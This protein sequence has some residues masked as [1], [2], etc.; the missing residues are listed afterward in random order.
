MLKSLKMKFTVGFIALALL[1]MLVSGVYLIKVL[2]DYFIGNL[3]DKLLVEAKL[4]REMVIDEFGSLNRSSDIEKITGNLGNVTSTRV[5]V[6]DANGVVLGDS[7]QLPT[8]MENHLRRPEIQQAISEGL[9]IAK[10]EST[11]LNTQMMYLA[12]PVEKDGEI[13]G[14]VRLALPMTE[15]T[16]ALSKLWSML[17]IA[18]LM[19]TVIAGVLGF[20]L[21]QRLTKPIQEMTAAAQNIAGGDFSLR[22]YTT[23]QDEIG[24]LGQALNQ[25]AQQLKEMI[26]EVSTGKSKLETVLANMVSGVIFLRE[27]GKIDLIN[28]AALK[29]LEIEPKNVNRHQ[30]EIINNYQLSTL[31]DTAL[32]THKAAKDD[33][34]ILSPHEKNIEVNITPILGKGNTNIGAVMVLH[35]ITDLRKLETM[36][37]DFVANVSHELKTPVTSLKGYAETLLDGALDDPETARE[38]VRIILTESERLR[39]LVDDLL[40]LSRI[41]SGKDSVEWQKI[42]VSA[43][44]HSL[45]VKFRPQLEAR[46]IELTVVCSEKL[47]Y[48]WGDYSM[49]EQVLTNLT[50]NAIKYSAIREKV[51]IVASEKS[52]GILFEVIDSGPGIPEH[53]LPRVFERFYRVDKGRNRKQGGTG[54]GLAIVKHILETHGVGIQVESTLGRGSRFYFMLTKKP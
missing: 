13:K 49:I 18:L 21:S 4:V 26:D 33:L 5:T 44:L 37:R 45:E 52:D 7:E 47:P 39:M 14:F 22:T 53:D 51:K 35:D 11:T 34:L 27:D 28:P 46:Q 30:I 23:S 31:I 43:L 10:R 42:D 6:I 9:G 48:A 32:K 38:F 12:L 8:L 25:M 19:A 50:D 24:K 15:I 29:I 20:K 1:S 54:L 40:E 3:Q 41:E 17:F 2:D 36:R 16:T